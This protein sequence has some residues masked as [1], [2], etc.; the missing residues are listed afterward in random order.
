MTGIAIRQTTFWGNSKKN[1]KPGTLRKTLK[2]LV[3]GGWRKIRRRPR[4]WKEYILLFCDDQV[5]INGGGDDVNYMLRKLKKELKKWGLTKNMKKPSKRWLK[6]RAKET[7]ISDREFS[8][9]DD[10]VLIDGN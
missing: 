6:K 5:L 4:S 7:K 3:D 2:N 1:T 10:Q 8:F 9:A